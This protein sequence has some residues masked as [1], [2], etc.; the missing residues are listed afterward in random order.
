MQNVISYDI[1]WPMA[2]VDTVKGIYTVPFKII[3]QTSDK[4]TEMFC[5]TTWPSLMYDHPYNNKELSMFV[6]MQAYLRK[7][8]NKNKTLFIDGLYDYLDKHGWFVN[9][10][11][12][13]NCFDIF[14]D[15]VDCK[16]WNDKTCP[17]LQ[18]HGIISVDINKIIDIFDLHNWIRFE[19]YSTQIF[20]EAFYLKFEKSIPTL[21]TFQLSTAVENVIL[22]KI[23][24]LVNNN[25]SN[26][27]KQIKKNY[28]INGLE[29]YKKQI[30][31]ID[32]NKFKITFTNF[33]DILKLRTKNN[34]IETAAAIYFAAK[35][36][37]NNN[38]QKNEIKKQMTRLTFKA[39]NDLKQVAKK[40]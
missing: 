37:D 7:T 2:K 39:L 35:A 22:Q 17:H 9:I 30:E 36:F 29:K 15:K 40:K 1:E 31:K 4:T 16:M 3:A 11:K 20:S 26:V 21:L 27:Y 28:K 10:K 24:Q 25:Q 6:K 18:V 34:K 23:K 8:L 19:K 14:I 33:I 38:K 12:Q 32:Q 13:E 5:F